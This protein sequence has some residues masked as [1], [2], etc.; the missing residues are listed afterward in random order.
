MSMTRIIAGTL[1]GGILIL[2]ASG[3]SGQAYP[4]K[5]V[6]L[7]SN[8]PGGGNDLTARMIAEGIAGHL[9]K[10]V[11]VENR[12]ALIATETGKN[13]QPDGYTMLAAGNSLWNLQHLR[14]NASYHPEDFSPITMVST[15]PLVLVVYPGLPVKSVKELIS[16]AKAKPGELN[17]STGSRGSPVH[18]APVLFNRM[19][20]VKI[21]EVL[22]KSAT[23]S[24]PSVI[25]GEVQ[26]TFSVAT[27]VG[28]LTKA[29]KVRALAVT[30][31]QPTA[32]VPGLPT[33]AGSGLPGY[34]IT[35]LVGIYVPA[36]TPV[37]IVR[38]LNQEIVRV[39]NQPD[40]KQ[41]IF[42]L[43]A[44]IVAN[45]PEQHA[46]MIKSENATW[47]KVIKDAGIRED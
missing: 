31:A 17:Y 13:A 45:S 6:R 47:G 44:D 25:S 39:L 35:Q 11:I 24:L 18:L 4:N 26:M 2:G 10:P 16:L 20:G 15:S 28:P 36:M 41:K 12:A 1:C 14:A 43:G 34:E 23:G 33:V 32:L 22:F 9:G 19:A 27:T 21:V 30:S 40:V 46:A 42:A 38:R 29:G 3:A 37:A 7:L 5:P 8:T